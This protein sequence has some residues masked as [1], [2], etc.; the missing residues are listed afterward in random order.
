MEI[1][2]KSNQ[3]IAIILNLIIIVMELISATM[4]WN[5]HGMGMFQFYTEDSNF[6]LLLSS[7]LITVFEIKSLWTGVFKMP[8]WVKTIKYMAVCCVTVTFVVVVCILAPLIGGLAGYQLMLFSHSMLFHHLLCPV[9]AFVSFVYFEREPG[10]K[11]RAA[12]YALAPTVLYAV[13]AI[14]LNI[15]RVMDGPYPF[16]KVYEQTIW[17]SVFWCVVILGGAY[18]FALLIWRLNR[19]KQKY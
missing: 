19:K 14:T 16:L 6:F 8:V 3:R 5:E 1:G 18:L 2:G 10:L 7:L 15:I 13:V 17:I 11:R 9:A 12:L 4:S